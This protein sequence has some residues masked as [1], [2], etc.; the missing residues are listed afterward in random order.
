MAGRKE[1]IEKFT[2]L[3]KRKIAKTTPIAIDHD[4]D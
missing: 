3:A 4:F 2:G 1:R